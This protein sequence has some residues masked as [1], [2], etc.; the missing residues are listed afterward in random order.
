MQTLDL[1]EHKEIRVIFRYNNVLETKTS[2]SHIVSVTT[3]GSLVFLEDGNKTSEKVK[4][5]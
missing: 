5:G 3:I 1:S 4:Y 2:F